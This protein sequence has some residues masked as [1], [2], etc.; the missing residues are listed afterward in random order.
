M[1]FLI[2]SF[3]TAMHAKKKKAKVA[4]KK[5]MIDNQPTG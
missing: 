5:M 4:K 2:R 1:P 3:L